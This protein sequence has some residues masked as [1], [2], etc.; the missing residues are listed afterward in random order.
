MEIQWLQHGPPLPGLEARGPHADAVAVF[1]TTGDGRRK[2][3]LGYDADGRAVSPQDRELLAEALGLDASRLVFMEQVHGGLAT[4][5]DES[6]AGAGLESRATAVHGVDALVTSCGEVA[7]VGLS[8]DCPLVAMWDEAGTVGAVAHAGWRSTTGGIVRQ[9]VEI[10]VGLGAAPER[11]R[12][13]LSP[14]IGPCCY[15]VQS[16]LVAAMT[17]AGAAREEDFLRREGR[18]YLDLGAAVERQLTESG[19]ARERISGTFACTMC[20][21]GLFHSYRRD[22]ARAG[23]QAMGL[24]LRLGR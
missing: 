8:A 19:V 22:G 15:E 4:A 16:D 14:A 11:I 12:A 13:A 3:E 18:V 1:V 6:A 20:A 7:L 21:S 9:T 10:M 2:P 23:R 24:R 17:A 5:V